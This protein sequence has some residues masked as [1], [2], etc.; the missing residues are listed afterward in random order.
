MSAGRPLPRDARQL[1]REQ[2]LCGR[3]GVAC[4]NAF[5]RL[6]RFRDPT[7]RQLEVVEP[8]TGSTSDNRPRNSMPAGDFI[9]ALFSR[10]ATLRIKPLPEASG[11]R[12]LVST[13]DLRLIH[14]QYLTWHLMDR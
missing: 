12:A 3:K 6:F 10:S 13:P 7:L 5:D 1:L 4:T 11:F 8:E 14:P 2:R 9:C